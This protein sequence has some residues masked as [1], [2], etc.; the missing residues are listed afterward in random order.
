MGSPGEVDLFFSRRIGIGNDGDLVPI[1]GGARLS[2]KVGN[3]NVGLLSMFTDDVEEASIEKN[4]Y[5]VVRAN[6]DFQGTR[7]SFGGH[8]H[9]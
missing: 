2:G 9:Q 6:H 7:S 4:N 8:V 1:I 3:T 5:S